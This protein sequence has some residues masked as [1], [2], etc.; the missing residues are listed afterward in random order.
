MP[1]E[2]PLAASDISWTISVNVASG[3]G[4]YPGMATDHRG[5]SLDQHGKDVARMALP[6]AATDKDQTG[7]RCVAGR[8]E[9]DLGSFAIPVWKY[10]KRRRALPAI[11]PK[12]RCARRSTQGVHR[13]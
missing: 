7:R 6:I 13:G 12:P 5:H 3:A 11:S 1:R 4:E 2:G 8:I 10:P 9:I